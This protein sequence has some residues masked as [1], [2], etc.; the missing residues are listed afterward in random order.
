MTFNYLK[1]EGRIEIDIPENE[2]VEAL[3]EIV[4]EDYFEKLDSSE[5]FRFLVL[6]GLKNYYSEATIKEWNEITN[7]YHERLKDMFEVSVEV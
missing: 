3:A 1:G 4:F 5:K 6:Q 2:V 7:C